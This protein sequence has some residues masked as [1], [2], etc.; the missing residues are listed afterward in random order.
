M[1]G[2]TTTRRLSKN[3]SLDM[4]DKLPLHIL[5]AED[6]IINQ[7]LLLRILEMLGYQA[8]TVAD[9]KEVLHTVKEK[10]YDLVLMD[11][12][13][14]EMGGEEATIHLRQQLKEGAPKIIAVTAYAMAGDRDKYI[15]A[16]MDGYLSKPFKIDDLVTEIRRVMNH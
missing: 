2:K 1:A 6:N 9:G 5:I 12:Q 3:N 4:A 8:D 7:K 16:G 10:T 11:I 13:M 15:N 14:P